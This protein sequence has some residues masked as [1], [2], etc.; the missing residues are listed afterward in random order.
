[1]LDGMC[2]PRVLVCFLL[3]AGCGSDGGGADL[4]SAVDLAD[5]PDLGTTDLATFTPVLP[6]SLPIIPNHGGPVIASPQ[7]V[8]LTW[9]SDSIA[10]DLEAFDDWQ[11]TSTFWSDLMAEWGVGP[12]THAGSY[13]NPNPAPA[14]LDEAAV[15]TLIDS[16]VTAGVVPT[17]T[18]S[19]IYT[20]YPPSGTTVTQSGSFMGCVDFQAYH[21]V[22]TVKGKQAFYAIAPR[23]ATTSGLSALDFTTWGMSH[24]VM[25]AASDPDPKLPAWLI[26][27]QS[28]TTPE[29]GE[30]ADLCTGHPTKI[31]GH[32]VTRNY[33]NVAAMAGTRPCVPAPA[34]PM[35]GVFADP[36]EVTITPGT[37][38][39]V[40][41]RFYSTAPLAAFPISAVARS[42]DLTVALSR[43]TGKNG[44]TATLTITAA[45]GYVEYPGANLVDLRAIS[46]GYQTRHNLIVH[47]P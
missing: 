15:T 35:F 19:I 7:I 29:L 32:E 3:V 6:P 45:A 16:A 34:G 41:V 39:T 4:S 1:M 28:P 46:S 10:A 43:T 12:G 21:S 42:A 30:N 18:A 8:S 33:S 25:E 26:N 23:C 24:E 37:Q 2:T 20:I 5:V 40:T 36:G 14:T 47:T 22:T 38:T 31:Q 17:P 11:V 27:T 13:R 9:Q 44:D